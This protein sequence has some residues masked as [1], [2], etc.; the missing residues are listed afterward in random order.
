MDFSWSP[1]QKNLLNAVEHFASEKL[2]GNLVDAD[3][4]HRFNQAG[5]KACGEFGVQGLPAPTEYGGLGMDPLTTV[6]AL[7]RLGYT[8]KDNGLIFSINA[9]LWTVVMPLVAAGTK[10]QK[11]KYL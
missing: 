3:R 8:C 11:Q 1:E 9:H 2:Q 6:A 7:E 4:N 5:W 10:Q